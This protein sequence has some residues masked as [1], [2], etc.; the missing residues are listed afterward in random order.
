MKQLLLIDKIL[1]FFLLVISLATLF[2]GF[3]NATYFDNVFA[4]EDGF[5]EYATFFFLL[6]VSLTQFSRLRKWRGK[7]GLWIISVLFLGLLFFFGAGEEISWGQRIFN[8]ESGDFFKDN[9]LQNETNLHNLKIGGV[10]LN[11]LIFTQLLGVIMGIYLLI[12]PILYNK[13]SWLKNTVDSF[14]IPVPKLHQII[15]F[16]TT[17]LVIVVLPNLSRKPEIHELFFACIFFLI[18]LNPKNKQEVYS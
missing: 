11:K 1:Y 2:F 17:S 4:Q 18:F 7:K 12:L 8:I 6:L 16:L 14:A 15:A 3:T 10:K 5:I 9:N 13:W